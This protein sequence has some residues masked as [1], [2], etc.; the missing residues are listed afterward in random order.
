MSE[1][2]GRLKPLEEE[3]LEKEPRVKEVTQGARNLL[4][5]MEKDGVP[6]GEEVRSA[7]ESAEEQWRSC[8]PLLEEL[9][10]RFRLQERKADLETLNSDCEARLAELV[11][12]GPQMKELAAGAAELAGELSV[13]AFVLEDAAALSARYAALLEELQNRDLELSRHRGNVSRHRGNVSRH[14]THSG[15]WRVNG[16]QLP[17]RI[18]GSH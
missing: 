3:I 6:G 17:R 14:S 10:E 12:L 5:Q 18:S 4:E 13:P 15:Q 9:K 1:A 7:L 16:I 8:R 11:A 2:E